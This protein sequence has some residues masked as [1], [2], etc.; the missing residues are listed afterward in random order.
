MF[1]SQRVGITHR[2]ERAQRVAPGHGHAQVVVPVG[3]GVQQTGFGRVPANAYRRHAF[4]DATHHVRADAFFQ[5][6]LDVLVFGF[7]QEF[8]DLVGQRFSHDRSCGQHVHP[9]LDACRVAGHVALDAAGAQQ[10]AAGVFQQGFARRG[11]HDPVLAS[12]QQVCAHGGFE[13]GQP[14]AHRRG[15]HVGL[16]GGA[17]HVARVADGHEQAQ[18]GQVEVT[19][20]IIPNGNK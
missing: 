4:A 12:G 13:L 2:F 17:A 10:H 3:A 20:Q 7:F 5:I 18:R 14:L 8:G 1:E 16:F 19:H 15:D 6:D 11:G 9:T